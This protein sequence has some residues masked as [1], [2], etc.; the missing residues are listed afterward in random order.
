MRLELVDIFADSARVESLWKGF[1]ERCDCSYFQSWGWIENWLASLP[2]RSRVKLAV[3]WEGL[4]PVSAFFLGR[5]NVVNQRLFRSKAYL[6]NQTGQWAYDRLYIEHNLVFRSAAC[7]ASLQQIIELLPPGWE[8]FYLSALAP[9]SFPANDLAQIGPPYE[10]MIAKEIPSPYVDLE[11]V[12]KGSGDYLALLGSNVR[13]QIRRARRL[14]EERGPIVCEAACDLPSALAIYDELIALHTAS[15]RKRKKPGAFATAYF[16][17]F[18]RHLIEKRH[19][20]GE[21]QL[22]RVRAGATTIGC[23]YNFVYRGTVHFYQ[24]GLADESDNRFKP[25]YLCHAE[26]VRLNAASGLAVY[27]FLAGF[28]DYKQRLS[29]HQRTLVWARVQKPRLKFKLERLARHLALSALARYQEY[30]RAKRPNPPKVAE[31]QA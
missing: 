5:E 21:V 27:D 1:S 18:H 6:L 15:W 3:F 14:Y 30:K 19:A 7:T 24:S 23:V 8:E 17:D 26:A 22:L 2:R 13:S 11:L 25:G 31:V 29:T 28:E 12:R 16:R 20:A 9:A 4:E 10:L